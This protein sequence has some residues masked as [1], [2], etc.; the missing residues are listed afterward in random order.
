MGIK[1]VFE[2]INSIRHNDIVRKATSIRFETKRRSVPVL[3]KRQF[4]LKQHHMST[5]STNVYC[6]NY[7][8]TVTFISVFCS[9]AAI[10]KQR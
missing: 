4:K 3:Q 10:A 1:S 7:T 2:I 5:T 6:V 8:E 9:E